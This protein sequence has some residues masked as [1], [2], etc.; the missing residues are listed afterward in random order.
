MKISE[1]E[2]SVM[3]AIWE[4]SPV[5]ADT[6]VKRLNQHQE[7]H[8]KTVKTLLN[9]LVKKQAL[10]FNKVGRHYQ[11]FPLISEDSYQ[12]KETQN[13]VYRVFGGRVSP[14]LAGFIK[15]SD[16]SAEDVKELKQLI[17]DLDKDH[18]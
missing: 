6:I 9:R 3:Q 18:D 12:Q 1:A 5:D 7:W 2:L 13:F 11:Y 15:Q 10:G 14:L 4:Q 17:A 16:L 8:E